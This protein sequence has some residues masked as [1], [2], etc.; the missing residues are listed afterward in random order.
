MVSSHFICLLLPQR[1]GFPTNR[2]SKSCQVY[3]WKLAEQIVHF[4][5]RVI[6]GRD[7]VKEILDDAHVIIDSSLVRRNSNPRTS[8]ASHIIWNNLVD[9]VPNTS[10]MTTSV[11]SKRKHRKPRLKHWSMKTETFGDLFFESFIF[12]IPV[13]HIHATHWEKFTKNPCW[14]VKFGV[15]SFEMFYKVLRGTLIFLR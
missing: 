9:F 1:F 7:D 6:V 5:K 12:Q 14:W 3:L 10:V 11:A 8:H 4:V 15:T 13:V 2:E